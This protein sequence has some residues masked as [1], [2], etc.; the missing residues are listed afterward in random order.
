L[1]LVGHHLQ[2]YYMPVVLKVGHMASRGPQQIS[3]GPQKL[4]SEPPKHHCMKTFFKFNIES[5]IPF[6]PV[7]PA[8]Q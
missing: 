7:S 5:K 8:A 6:S 4:L 1:H 2:L 3:K